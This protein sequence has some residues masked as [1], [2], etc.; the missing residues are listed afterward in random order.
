MDLDPAQLGHREDRRLDRDERLARPESALVS[1]LSERLAEHDVGGQFDH[2][3]AGHLAQERH[4]AG[5]ARIDL[6]D[7]E[8]A[9]MDHVLDV[10]QAPRADRERDP[11]RVVDDRVDLGRVETD[12]R[13]DR[14]RVAGV[15]SGALDVLHDRRGSG[16]PRR[17]RSRRPRLPCRVG[18]C[19]PEPGDRASWWPRCGCSG[20]GGPRCRRPP[21][22]GRRARTMVGPAPDSR[23]AR[24]HRVGIGQR[25]DR[26]AVRLRECRGRAGRLRT[27]R[28]PRRYRSIPAS[29]RGSVTPRS[30][31][32]SARLIAV[33]P[34]NWTMTGGIASRRPAPSCLQH[35]VDALGI[36]RLEVEAVGGV[37]V[38]RDRLRVRVDHDRGVR[39]RHAAPGRPA[40][41]NSRTRCP[42]RSGSARSRRRGR[43]RRRAGIAS[44]SSS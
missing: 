38:G 11:G 29:C 25:A 10:D 32:G 34:P 24:R 6:E 35:L 39:R 18:T 22:P 42:A 41:S 21:S 30:D 23:S 37:E 8:P 14:E 20:R 33:W 15:H 27:A 40:P 1:L 28:G 9:G 31:S 13:V 44:S 26:R 17:R 43:V 5:R 36:Q 19:R 16:P 7:V 2:R 4:G 12:A 3:H